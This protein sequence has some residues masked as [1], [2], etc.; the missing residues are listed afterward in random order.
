MK[1][2]IYMAFLALIIF[3]S[4]VIGMLN[5]VYEGFKSVVEHEGEKY[6]V[7]GGYNQDANG[8]ITDANDN[9]V[10]FQNIRSQKFLAKVYISFVEDKEVG[11]VFAV[12][13]YYKDNDNIV[14]EYKNNA[15]TDI[16]VLAEKRNAPNPTI[17][18]DGTELEIVSSYYHV[19]FIKDTA[20]NKVFPVKWYHSS[21]DTNYTFNYGQKDDDKQ[22]TN[23]EKKQVAPTIT[24]GT[25]EE[26]QLVNI[27]LSNGDKE[28]LYTN[29][30]KY[31][32][33]DNSGERFELPKDPFINRYTT[34]TTDADGDSQYNVDAS[35]NVT[36][37][38]DWN[39]DTAFPDYHDSA[40][41]LIDK[42]PRRKQK[43][44]YV[45]GKDG[46]LI[47]VPWTGKQTDINYNEPE[48]NYFRYQPSTFVPN[49]EDSVYLSRLT[50]LS[51]T[52]PV[53]DTA[54][55]KGGFCEYHKNSPIKIEEECGKLEKDACAST[56]CCV[57]L[58]GS[59]CVGGNEKGPT[60]KANYSDITII[61]RDHYFYKGKCYGNCPH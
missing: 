20:I 25:S 54:S 46:K 1:S 52:K 40:S 61:N 21:T 17:K 50:G 39:A 53:E 26:L 45:K 8:A 7:Y 55:K 14:F 31:A 19:S 32:M 34:T 30:K 4:L 27:N 24:K 57:L 18:N 29:N 13:G 36:K 59:R 56:S 35:G 41:S 60:M 3:L 6:V 11:R 12:K 33:N 44:M 58:G 5:P 49:Y 43:K 48:S 42:D 22:Y 9:V 16:T 38:E 37:N 23:D 47:E 10:Q 51:T 28:T 2:Y 15:G